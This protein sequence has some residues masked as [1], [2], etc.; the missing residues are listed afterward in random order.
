MNA[1]LPLLSGALA[2]VITAFVTYLIARRQSS[3][4]VG[5]SDAA[6]LWEESQAMRKELR[7][8]VRELRIEISQNRKE[9]D[10]LR[11]RIRELEK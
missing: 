1:L 10:Q 7:D 8:E 6:T 4:R 5:T 9:I 3:G 11:T 2:A